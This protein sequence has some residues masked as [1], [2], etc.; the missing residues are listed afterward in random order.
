MHVYWASVFILPIGILNEIEQLMCGFLWCQG[1][2]HRGKEKVTWNDVCLPKVEGGLGIRKL[3]QFNIAL[4][5]SHIWKIL[6]N[7]DL[8]WVRWIHYYKLKHR[9]FWD[10]KIESNVSRGWR[11]LLKIHNIIRPHIWFIIGDGKEASMWF[12]T[13]DY[14]CPLVHHLS[15]RA[16][17]NASFSIHDKV[18]DLI[19]DNAWSLPADGTPYTH[20]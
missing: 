2:Y 9:R 8:L 11:K 20:L 6:M 15:Y 17:H 1:D 13:L 14:N 3:E 16:I 12:D 10:V 7:K 19:L 5:S 4:M 18:A